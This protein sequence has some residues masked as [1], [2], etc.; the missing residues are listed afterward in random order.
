MFLRTV[1]SCFLLAIIAA[2]VLALGVEPPSWLEKAAILKLPEN[3]KQLPAVVLQNQKHVT[4]TQDGRVTT[5]T[6]FAVRILVHEGRDY[7]FARQFYESDAG[8]VREMQAWLIRPSGPV[9]RYGKD[10]I[11]DAIEDSDDVYNESRYKMIDATKDADT[12]AVFGYQT[13]TEERSIFS[14]D[15]FGFQSFRLPTLAASY[16]LSLPQ[17]W[18]ATGVAFNHESLEPIVSLSNY[19]WE[20][21][22]IPPILSEP[23]S[24]RVLSL[25]PRLAVSYFP[26]GDTKSIPLQTYANWTEV[27]RWLTG[28][29]DPQW[30]PDTAITE[31]AKQLT[32]GAK[33]ELEKIRAIGRYV[34]SIRYISIQIGVS[35]GGGMRPHSAAEVFAKSYGDC[36]DKANLMRAM[37]KVLDIPAYPVVIYSVDPT[38]VREE[39]ASPYQFN[40]CIIAVK[41]SDETQAATVI[42]HPKL[43][44]LLI[45]DATD[46]DTP[47]GDLP[48]HEQGS[49]ALVLAGDAGTLLRMP[50]TPPEANGLERKI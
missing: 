5:V 18:H 22:D 24:P 49:F 35:R 32:T 8:K 41:V 20:I 45:F 37:L 16:T 23:G 1:A 2:P 19:T 17:G 21:R 27:S 15:I 34:Q 47:V 29:H 30:A 50:V 26:A 33:T 11:I 44:R 43:G 6:T 38:Y 42:T 48:E 9:K 39:W 7:A 3:E 13:T 10:E 12:G 28:L 14:Q 31:K 4:V 46:D 36:K 25:A 40:H